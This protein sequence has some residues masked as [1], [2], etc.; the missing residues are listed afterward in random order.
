MHNTSEREVPTEMP[1]YD[2]IIGKS[3]VRH[4]NPMIQKLKL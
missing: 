4:S 3:S 2:C 1:A